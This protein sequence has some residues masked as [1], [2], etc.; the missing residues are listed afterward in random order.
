MP[1]RFAALR[2]VLYTAADSSG[3]AALASVER[4]H[5]TLKKH[6]LLLLQ[7]LLSTVMTRE[8]ITS[9]RH[10]RSVSAATSATSIRSSSSSSSSSNVPKQSPECASCIRLL[11]HVLSNTDSKPARLL[12]SMSLP[13]TTNVQQQQQ[14][15]QHQ[16]QLLFQPAPN[17]VIVQIPVEQ[18]I[19]NTTTTSTLLP[20]R[21]ENTLPAS[22]EPL[23]RRFTR[24][25][26][27]SAT[28]KTTASSATTTAAA[29]TAVSPVLATSAASLRYQPQLE[30]MSLQC[31]HCGSTGPEGN[32]RA[33]VM[34]PTPLSIVVCHNRLQ[35]N[36]GQY[37]F[38]ASS[39]F[40]PFSSSRTESKATAATDAPKLFS[41][42][43]VAEMSEILTHELTHIYDVRQLHL[44]LTS[45]QDLA[46]SEVRAAREA[47]CA[48][49]PIPLAP[50]ATTTETSSSSSS[51]RLNNSSNNHYHRNNP[52]KDCVQSTATAATH[53]LFALKQAQA[54]VQSVL[55]RA[56]AD[57][58]PFSA[59]TSSS[60]SSSIS[61]LTT[62]E[63]SDRMGAPTTLAAASKSEPT[64]P[65]TSDDM[66]SRRQASHVSER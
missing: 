13:S 45:C 15:Q 5:C 38:K 16:Q 18:K 40:A 61:P 50:A 58:R 41:A 3:L 9:P 22:S 1:I 12:Q 32:A 29:P 4:S 49:V 34:G 44:D 66:T 28:T 19:P 52:Q 35:H 20:S 8:P 37:A 17:G 60:S 42:A 21:P 57:H 33:F 25:W 43:A 64:Q 63:T 59:T 46:Y 6:W 26:N 27:T 51:F 2:T 14:Q 65:T 48:A 11:Q 24:G 10:D 23:L 39:F 30:G 55:D 7:S 36:N 62:L 31:R 56:Y 53:N 47:E 54:C